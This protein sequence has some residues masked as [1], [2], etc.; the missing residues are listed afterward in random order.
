MKKPLVA[1]VGK[2]NVGKS[3]FFNKVAGSKI[4]IVEDI[5]GVT[6][7]RIFANAEWCGYSFQIVDTGGLD[8]NK[9]D[10]INNR[11]IEQAN[12]AIDLADVIIFFVDGKTGLTSHDVEVANHLRRATAPKILAVNKL[13]NHE[14]EKTYEFYELGLGDPIAVS[15]EQS[16]GIGDLLDE[17]VKHL[18]KNEKE[19]DDPAVKIALVGKP[20]AG[21]SSLTNSLLGENRVAVSSIAGTTR[22]AVDSPFR[23]NNK[24]Y[25]LIDTAGLRRKS[26]IEPDSIERYSVIRSLNAIER[27]DVVVLVIDASEGITEQDVKIA[28]LIDEQGKPSVIVVNKWD[29]IENSLE[30]RKKFEKQFNDDLAFM[31]YYVTVYTSAVTGQKLG[32]IMEKVNY[33]LENARREIPMA[34]FNNVLTNAVSVTEPPAKNGRKVKIIFGKQVA[35][36][37]PTFSIYCNNASLIDNSYIRYIENSL[38]RAFNFEGTPIKVQFKNKNEN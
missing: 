11:I 37:P 38:R 20:N 16:K 10:E 19:E 29:L 26:K 2:P 28:G 25:C 4:S 30:E 7:D 1:I 17:V 9:E 34:L 6:R 12:L 32:Q 13:D 24:D 22:D 36:C 27:A 8:F 33:V 5:P 18:K 3:T 23:W 31:K 21:K 35:T 14:V 15:A